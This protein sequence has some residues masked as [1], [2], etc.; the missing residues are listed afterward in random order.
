[1]NPNERAL[2]EEE[3]ARNKGPRTGVEM[4]FNNIVASSRTL[5]ISQIIAS[6][7]VEDQIGLTCCFCGTYRYCF[8]ICLHVQKEWGILLMVCLV[9]LLLLLQSICILQIAIC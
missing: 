3:D 7:R 5:I 1:M 8:L 6:C 4:S 2:A 9:Y